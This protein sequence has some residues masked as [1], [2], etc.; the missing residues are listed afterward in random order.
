M[1]EEIVGWLNEIKALKQKQVELQQEL[2]N[3][4]DQ[5][6]NWRKLYTTEAQQ[7]RLETEAAEA[8]LQEAQLT[9]KELT[10][11]GQGDGAAEEKRWAAINRDLEGV[12]DI[13]QLKQKLLDAIK[14]RDQLFQFLQRER[15][16]HEQTRRSL[17]AVIG[18][19]VDKYVKKT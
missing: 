18:D 16:A 13:T 12:E 4:R 9:I 5:E 6:E 2:Q 19:T 14:E 11:F 10:D 8:Q 17:T 1:S 7:R 15:E 3:A